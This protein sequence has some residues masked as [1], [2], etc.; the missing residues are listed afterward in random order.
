MDYDDPTPAG[1]IG[2]TWRWFPAAVVVTVA[3]L[4]L[5][6]GITVVGWQANWWFAS[7]NA[8]RQAEITQNGYSNQTTLRQQVTANFATLSQIGVQI[9]ANSTDSSLVTALKVQIAS[10]AVQVCADAA[11]ITGTPL[12]ASQAQWVAANCS[13]GTLSTTSRDYQAGQP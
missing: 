8:T 6:G 2:E 5:G 7:H 9:A 3:V 10:T 1:V 4:L 13:D 11:E 12:P